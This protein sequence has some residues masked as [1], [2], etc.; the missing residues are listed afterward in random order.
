[1]RLIETLTALYSLLR[2]CMSCFT[3]GCSFG[4]WALWEE[5]WSEWKAYTTSAC[6]HNHNNV[7]VGI[8][9]WDR[10][11]SWCK[12]K[13]RCIATTDMLKWSQRRTEKS[14]S[15]YLCLESCGWSDPLLSPGNLGSGISSALHVEEDHW[16]LGEFRTYGSNWYILLHRLSIYWLFIWLL[17][18]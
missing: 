11:C 8:I 1:M 10:V 14:H 6:A 13:N 16:L 17:D 12:R 3:S 4:S 2:A 7:T 18:K 5:I 9:G 15:L